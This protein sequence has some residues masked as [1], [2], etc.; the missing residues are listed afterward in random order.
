MYSASAV[1][2]AIVVCLFDFHIIG[3]PA[4]RNV[5]PD[6]D[7]EVFGFADPSRVH[8]PA[9]S[10]STYSSMSLAR[11]GVMMVPL[12]CVPHKYLPMCRSA[13][14]W[15]RRGSLAYRAHW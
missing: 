14:A 10:A 13:A 5:Y 3:H 2:N 7:K 1:D 12:F 8:S 4:Y 15:L 6:L 9:K 11:S